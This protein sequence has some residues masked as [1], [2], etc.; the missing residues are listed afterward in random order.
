MTHNDTGSEWE[1]D[2]DA[3]M[4]SHDENLH[5]KKDSFWKRIN[6]STMDS[7]G[8]HDE[9][10]DK[11]IKDFIRTVEQKAY[12]NGVKAALLHPNVDV[13]E[14]QTVLKDL[15]PTNGNEV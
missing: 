10:D 9:I 11:K 3:K 2:F 14:I 4:Q 6:D 1:R 12:K 5:F 7:L 8:F 13:N 15:T